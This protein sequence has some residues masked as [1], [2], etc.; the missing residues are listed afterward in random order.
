MLGY[1]S[2]SVVLGAE[3]YPQTRRIQMINAA[4][5]RANPMAAESARSVGDED[6][7]KLL[8]IGDVVQVIGPSSKNA[9]GVSYLPV[10]LPGREEFFWVSERAVGSR[11]PAPASFSAAAAVSTGGSARPWWHW[12]V[13]GVAG[14]A[15]LGGIGYL[16]LTRT[17]RPR[18]A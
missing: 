7:A 17:P 15:L 6:P 5:Y 13:V 8:Q 10:M 14:A 2:G 18:V 11:M 3:V 4:L 9:R 16:A 12:A 1:R